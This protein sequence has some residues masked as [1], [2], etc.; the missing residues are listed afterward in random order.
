MLKR[1]TGK[2]IVCDMT[3]TSWVNYISKS[4]LDTERGTKLSNP[5]C[6]LTA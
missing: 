3:L 6:A 5:A 2:E 1:T 4:Q